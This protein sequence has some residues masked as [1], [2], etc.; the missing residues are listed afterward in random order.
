MPLSGSCLGSQPAGRGRDSRSRHHQ[1][2]KGTE[3]A[4]PVAFDTLKISRKLPACASHADRKAAGFNE[5]QADALV[6]ALG[7]AFGDLSAEQADTVATKTDIAVLK[8]DIAATKAD[9]QEV[10]TG[11]KSDMKILKFVYG[12]IFLGLLLKITFF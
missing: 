7:E 10:R 1:L 11:L 5:P 8:A 2:P 9:V 3:A 6:D 12:P 4:I